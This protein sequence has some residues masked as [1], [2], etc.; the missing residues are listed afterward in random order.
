[1]ADLKILYRLVRDGSLITVRN[2]VSSQAQR[3]YQCHSFS[4]ISNYM[5]CISIY[6]STIIIANEAKHTK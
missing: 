5:D 1:M 2:N 4:R 3:R 6:D